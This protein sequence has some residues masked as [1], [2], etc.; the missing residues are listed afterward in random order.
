MTI[1]TPPDLGFGY[2]DFLA[3]LVRGDRSDADRLPDFIGAEGVVTFVSM[4]TKV[5]ATASGRRATF[6]PQT[7][8]CTLDPETGRLI[9]EDG[10]FGVW[11]VVG[12]HSVRYQIVGSKVSSST[13]NVMAE[14]TEENPL[15]LSDLQPLI[16]T[17]ELQ[18][19]VNQSV[20][21]QTL[22][23][24]VR[25]EEAAL[26]AEAGGTGGGGSTP[27]TPGKSAYEVAVQQG[28]VGTVT[29]WLA[30]LRG[31][32]GTPGQSAY[33]L[34]V[35]GGF[36]GTQAQWLASLKGETSTGAPGKSAYE[37]AVAAGF[38]GNQAAWLASLKGTDGEDAQGTP[39][40]SAYEVA[41]ANGFVG[42]QAQWL[43]S[44]KGGDG[45]DGDD[46]ASAT[47]TLVPAAS[48]PPPA[49]SNPLHLY[50]KVA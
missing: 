11:L 14:H 13:I 25:A 4:A 35:A 16:P 47:V 40:A 18:F 32:T 12:Q 31:G 39:G 24:A 36:S 10:N 19:V 50:V 27:G 30:S 49:D 48:W 3:G 21:E 2:V 5:R 41:L 8:T 37:L 34:A 38:V 9:D 20:Y 17:P 33:Q 42:S 44:L 28:F 22:A 26:R 23:A 46:G 7:V 45:D 1:A 15:D 43:A 29:Q 6:F